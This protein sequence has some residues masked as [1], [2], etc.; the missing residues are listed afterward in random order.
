MSRYVYPAVLA[1]AQQD[2]K[3]KERELRQVQ[4]AL[5]QGVDECVRESV[6]E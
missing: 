1:H 6:S 4:E 2:T 5:N 3:Q